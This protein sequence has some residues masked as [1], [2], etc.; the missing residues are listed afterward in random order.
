MDLRTLR[1]LTIELEAM[2]LGC[3]KE[4]ALYPNLWEEFHTHSI[5]EYQDLLSQAKDAI[6][7][8]E[9]QVLETCLT[10]DEEYPQ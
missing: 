10:L 9:I 8:L 4:L 1:D 5:E 3:Q 2:I 6:K 7:V